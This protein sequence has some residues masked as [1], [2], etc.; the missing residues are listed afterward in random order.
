MTDPVQTA[1]KP[2]A[3]EMEHVRKHVRQHYYFGG[4]LALLSG[5]TVIVATQPFSRI[6]NIVVALAIAIIEASLVVWFFM[7]LSKEKR[8]MLWGALFTI[9]MALLLLF[10]SLL[11]FFDH[12]H[13]T[14]LWP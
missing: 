7:H 8:A 9:H 2:D 4:V 10:L 1:E 11:G 13:G 3:H 6:G 12:I 5:L 14:R